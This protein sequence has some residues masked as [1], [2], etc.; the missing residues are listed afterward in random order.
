MQYN[1]RIAEQLP[2]SRNGI[3]KIRCVDLVVSPSPES[4][5]LYYPKEDNDSLV[6]CYSHLSW[7]YSSPSLMQAI[8]R[9]LYG[10]TPEERVRAW[11]GKLRSETR[12]LDKEMR[13]VGTTLFCNHHISTLKLSLSQLEAATAKVRITV[14]QLAAK[15]DVKSARILAKEVVRSNKQQ[16]RL[17]VSK[18]RLGSIGTQL[19]QQLGERKL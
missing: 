3:G 8:N 17:S 14:R 4:V 13:Q 6:S 12:Q 1:E 16:D 11:Q 7:K 15:G 18:A 9:F 5:S 2:L 10:P 19:Q